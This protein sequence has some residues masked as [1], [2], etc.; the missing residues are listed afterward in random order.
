MGILTH[1]LER[2]AL[3]TATSGTGWDSDNW[4]ASASNDN[5]AL[6]SDLLSVA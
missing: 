5:I 2:T 4:F 6:A 3:Y 1:V